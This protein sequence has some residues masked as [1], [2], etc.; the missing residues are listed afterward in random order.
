MAKGNLILDKDLRSLFSN[1][2]DEQ[3]GQLI[4]AAFAC[5]DGEAVAFD[6]PILSAVYALIESKVVENDRKYAQRCEQ[7]TK[8]RKGY[9]TKDN[10]S[11]RTLTTVNERQEIE[12]TENN[13]QRSGC[14]KNKIKEKEI[15]DVLKD[16]NT[17]IRHKHGDYKHVLLSD[18]E[19]ERLK[20][21]YGQELTDK[22]I[23]VVDN[24]C[25]MSG[26]R[27]KN[28]N[29]VIRSWGMDRAKQD[30]QKKPEK[31]SIYDTGAL[32]AALVW[33]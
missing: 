15:K 21:D 32:E 13:G 2:P 23:R 19:M 30:Q 4:K 8:N 11:E 12:T 9:E 28:Y 25:E 14:N 33:Q 18:D 31:K 20:T 6:D 1:L 3:A 27:Y 7:N 17:D 24:Y 26:K 16:I 10:V 5:H 22:A 29:L